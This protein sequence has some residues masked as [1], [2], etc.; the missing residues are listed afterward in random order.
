VE[1]LCAAQCCCHGLYGGADYIVV[2]LLGC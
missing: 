1:G 2:G